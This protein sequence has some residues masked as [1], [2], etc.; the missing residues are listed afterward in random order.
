MLKR[1]EEGDPDAVR[2]GGLE[3]GRGSVLAPARQ[4]QRM[5]TS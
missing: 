4:T 5:F 1:G 3:R 2:V